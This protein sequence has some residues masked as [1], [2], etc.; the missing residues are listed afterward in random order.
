[1]TDGGEYSNN[2]VS[3]RDASESSLGELDRVYK[4]LIKESKF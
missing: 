3:I 2:K 1:M 4:K